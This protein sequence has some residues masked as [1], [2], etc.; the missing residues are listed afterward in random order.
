VCG[1]IRGLAAEG[2]SVSVDLIVYLPR[3][4]MPAPERWANAIRDAGFPVEL[5]ADFDPDT[6]TGFRPCRFRGVQSGFEYYSSRLSEQERREL[7][8]PPGCNFSVALTT[9]AD[10]REFATSLIA[11]S[12]L[13]HVSGGLLVDPQSGEQLPAPGVLAWAREQLASLEG[14]LGGD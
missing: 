3:A 10:L 1:Q 8:A 9:H 14:E 12:V 13:C 5:D 11:A 7:G 6:A 2:G 4:S